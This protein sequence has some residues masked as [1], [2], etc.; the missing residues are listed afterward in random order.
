MPSLKDVNCVIELSES[1]HSLREFGTIYGDGFVETFVP[2]PSKPQSFSVHLTSNRFIAPGIAIFVYVDGVYQCNRNRQDLKLRKPSDSRS[3]V[4]FRVRQKE[5]KQEDG[6]MIAR[7]WTFDK[8]NIGKSGCDV[9]IWAKTDMQQHRP[10]ML[11]I[12]ARHT[13]SKTLAASKSWCCAV[14]VPAMLDLLLR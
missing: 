3:L 6:S 10:M 2:V 9:A 4:D 7:E 14:P 5:E 13:S 1:Q 12:F 11:Q 8:L